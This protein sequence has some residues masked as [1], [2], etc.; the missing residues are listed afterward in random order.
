M[1]P[2]NDTTDCVWCHILNSNNESWGYPINPMN[3]GPIRYNHSSLDITG[4]NNSEC[5]PCHVSK[6]GFDNGEISSLFNFHTISMAPGGGKNCSECHDLNGGAGENYTLDIKAMNITDA[7]HYGLNSG[8]ATLLDSNNERCW[9]CHGDGNGSEEAQPEG[10]PVN[11][12]NPKKCSDKECHNVNQSLFNEPMVYEHFKYVDEID[13]N[14]TTSADCEVCHLNSVVFHEDSLIP[15]DTSLVSHYGSVDELINTT[16]CVYCHLD[17]DNAEKWGDAPDPTDNVSVFSDKDINETLFVGDILNL[18]NRYILEFVDV[19]DNGDTARLKLYEGDTLL[20]DIVVNTDENYTYEADIIDDGSEYTEVIL[21]LNFTAVFIGEEI[22]LVKVDAKP[23]KRIHP[24][25]SDPTCWA[26]HMDDYTIDRSKYLVVAEDVDDDKK[27]IYY[28]EKLLD[29]SD[30]DTQDKASFST[31]NI[32]LTEGYN[33]TLDVGG[34][35]TLT[36]KDIDLDGRKVHLILTNKDG[37]VLEEDVYRVGDYLEYDEDLSYNNVDIY[38][39]VLFTAKVDSL[40]QGHDIDIAILTDIKV[41]SDKIVEIEDNET[42]GGYNTTFLHVNDTFYV[43]GIPDNFHVPTLNEGIDG[44][45]DCVYCHDTSK[46]FGIAE[47]NAIVS[48]LGGHSGLNANAAIKPDSGVDINK[49]CWACHGTGEDPDRHPVDY[50]Y[51]RQCEDCHVTLEEPTFDAVDLSEESHGQVG[52]CNRCHA[53]DYP[54]L[55]VINVFEPLTPYIVRINLTPDFVIPSDLM[56]VDI[57]AMAGW[58]MKVESIEYF[59]DTE[60][61][62]GSGT[63]VMAKDGAFDEQLED[64]QFTIDT[65]GLEFGN[66]TLYVHSM[67]RGMWGTMNKAVFSVVSPDSIEFIKSSEYMEFGETSDISPEDDENWTGGTLFYIMIIAGLLISIGF[68]F[69]R[70]LK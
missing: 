2:T 66:H 17:E 25:N 52:D 63:M 11:Y 67:E 45:S 65:S 26:C 42:I 47:V 12:N 64:A 40:F 10:H 54:G 37:V 59:V 36:A 61:P 4:T 1:T 13:Q 30:D 60:G 62:S 56:K 39:F 20:E 27:Y 23:W 46:D 38:D 44:S 41:F 32:V 5:Y 7:I 68:I 15:N 28:L 58:K 8:A 49:A 18:G 57:T 31:R 48:Q 19:A 33:Q 24:E 69:I 43:G 50:L 14:L 29:F 51:P 6:D 9:A 53:A 22:G 55:H 21:E 16:S 3:P 70:R 35:Y 34:E